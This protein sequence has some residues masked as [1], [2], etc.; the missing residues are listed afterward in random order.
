M[1][2]KKRH[3]QA[4]KKQVSLI[5]VYSVSQYYVRSIRY[6]VSYLCLFFENQHFLHLESTESHPSVRTLYSPLLSMRM[7]IF[8]TAN[9]RVSERI[10]LLGFFRGCSCRTNTQY[11]YGLFLWRLIPLPRSCRRWN[12]R[13]IFYGSQCIDKSGYAAIYD[14]YHQG[15]L[16]CNE[17]WWFGD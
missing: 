17:C 4:N 8:L 3:N 12:L 7:W 11:S 14:L 1:I 2:T 9:E 15:D 13:Q 10:C 16:L 6:L 5:L